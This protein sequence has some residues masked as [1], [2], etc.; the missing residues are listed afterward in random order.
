MS[1]EQREEALALLGL[2]EA[3]VGDERGW[4][5]PDGAGGATLYGLD[6]AELGSVLI[7]VDGNV[8]LP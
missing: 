6:G 1:P 4:N 7:D 5:G 2:V 3:E 8:S